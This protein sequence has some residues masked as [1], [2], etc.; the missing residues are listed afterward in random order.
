MRGHLWGVQCPNRAFAERS[1]AVPLTAGFSRC[2]PDILLALAVGITLLLPGAATWAYTHHASKVRFVEHSPEAFETA[3]RESKPV[4]L[5]ISA[6]WCYWCKYFDQKTLETDEVAMYL[7]RHYLSIFADHDRRM[8]I[9]RRYVRGLP[10]IVLFDPDGR[11]RQSF[12]GA[13]RKED[14]LSVLRRVEG[15]VR[16]DWAKGQSQAPLAEKPVALTPLPVVPQTYQQLRQATEDYLEEHLDTV[17]GGFGM[18]DKYPHARILTYLLERH[19]VTG[20]RSYLVMV[21][22]SLA[23]ILRGVYDPVEGGFFH[24]AEGR[25]WRRPH[26][27][28]LAHLNA[29]LAAVFDKAYRVTQNPRYKEAAEATITYLLRTLY[30]AE[31]GGFYGSQTADPAYYRLGAR[32]RRAVRKPP[33]NRDKLTAWN[34]EAALAFLALS[35]SSGRRD[36]AEAAGHTLEFMRRSCLTDKG[37]FHF[38]EHKTGRGSLRGQLEAN[39]WA[40]LAFVEGARV[41]RMDVYREAGERVLAYALLELFDAS[42]GAFAEEKNR[43]PLDANGVMALALLRAHQLT[44]R[45]EYLDHARRVL[46]ALGGTARAAVGEDTASVARVEKSAFYLRAYAR[47]AGRP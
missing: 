9:T 26:Y 33:V 37:M 38:Y 19:D 34:A 29:S 15:E 39:A 3:R 8:D 20:D 1:E 43:Y 21:E 46:G 10:M 17:H 7:N 28:K 6:V 41:L 24:Y 14:F 45:A 36:V 16:A 4:F 5:L 30:D 32:E 22:K 25:E 12:A 42:A 35:Q 11:I 47:V 44:G 40:A 13:L 31:A 27:E 23:G 2:R 18:G